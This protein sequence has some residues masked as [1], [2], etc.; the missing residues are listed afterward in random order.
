MEFRHIATLAGRRPLCFL[1]DRLLTATAT[2]LFLEEPGFGGEE[3]LVRLPGIASSVFGG[4]RLVE[5]ALRLG[6]HCATALDE[7][8]ALISVSGSIYRLDAKRREFIAEM[9][10]PRPFRPLCFAQTR[11][12]SENAAQVFFG[13]YGNNPQRAPVTIWRRVL[14][15]GWEKWHTFRR[16]AIEH[17]HALVEDLHRDCM[18]I[19]TG[20][21]GDAAAIWQADR[22][23]CEVHPVLQGSQ[24]ARAA[25]AHATV[26]GLLYATDSHM[27]PNSIRLLSDG[28]NGW[29]STPL[30]PMVGSSI[31]STRIGDDIVFSTAVEPPPPRGN[32]FL[33]ALDMRRGPGILNS[34]CCVVVGNVERGF[35]ESFAWRADRWPKRLFQFSTIQFPD[36]HSNRYLCM[37]G[38][39]VAGHDGATEV[40]ARD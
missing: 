11:A 14:G 3:K 9:P 17:V 6:V 36:G 5:R 23:G 32:L 40:Y 27:E 38:I 15:R 13:E 26:A 24:I 16:G 2:D 18:W 35:R 30:F 25:S 12:S 28:R 8:S 22:D 29:V 7:H 34:T 39:G 19:L 37:Y 4:L 20:D 31:G 10:W 33:D 21:Y 1:G